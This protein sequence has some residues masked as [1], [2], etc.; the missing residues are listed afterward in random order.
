MNISPINNNQSNTN[1]GALKSI[2]FGKKFKGNPKLQNQLLDAFEKSESMQKYCKKYRF[3]FLH[4][5]IF[6]QF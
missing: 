4:L 5:K 2:E 6:L 3:Y 1:F